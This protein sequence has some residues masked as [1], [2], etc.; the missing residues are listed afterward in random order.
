M[1]KPLK[2]VDPEISEAISMETRRQSE[3]L[4]LIDRY[5]P[6]VH[7]FLLDSGRP[8]LPVP[9]LGGTGRTH[10]WS[11]SARFVERSPRPVF[12]AGGLKPENAAEAIRAVRPYGLDLCSGV[13]KDDRLSQEKLRAF[14]SAVG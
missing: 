9:E 5:A 2:E 6:Y 3:T 14:M 7:A 4:E 11:L 12:L 1:D 8:S 10:D 13:R